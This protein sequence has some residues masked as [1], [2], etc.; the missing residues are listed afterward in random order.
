MTLTQ[1]PIIYKISLCHVFPVAEKA[2]C[3][4]RHE[5]PFWYMYLLSLKMSLST[6]IL[7]R[8]KQEEY[9]FWSLF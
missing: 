4:T 7:R 2:K 3:Y 6:L 1:L 8:K 9:Y 5:N